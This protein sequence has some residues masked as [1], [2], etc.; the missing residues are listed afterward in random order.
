MKYL[1]AIVRPEKLEAVKDALTEAGIH[2]MTVSDVQGYGRQRG[3]TETFAGRE[4]AVEF[5]RKAKI[6]IALDDPQVEPALRAVTR[7]ARSEAEG[8]IGDGK[9]FVLPLEDAIRI[10]TGERGADAL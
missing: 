10:R 4:Y 2:R 1:I 9:V 6:E 3:H 8:Q 7:A 5:V